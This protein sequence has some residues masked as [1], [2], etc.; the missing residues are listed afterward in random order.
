MDKYL[1]NKDKWLNK[2]NRL[3]YDGRFEAA[4]KLIN[5]GQKEM[6]YQLTTDNASEILANCGIDIRYWFVKPL[7]D[8]GGKF[9][10]PHTIEYARNVLEDKNSTL[11]KTWDTIPDAIRGFELVVKMTESQSGANDYY[12]VPQRV[13]YTTSKYY[14]KYLKYKFKYQKIKNKI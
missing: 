7:V 5:T 4:H 12:I 1:S 10:D 6:N 11:Y 14:H 13:G 8:L 3:V 9:S 2:I